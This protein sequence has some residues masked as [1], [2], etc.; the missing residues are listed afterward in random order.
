MTFQLSS[1][2]WCRRSTSQTGSADSHA[3]SAIAN[4]ATGF[5]VLEIVPGLRGAGGAGVP[6]YRELVSASLRRL[7]PD[8]YPS[9]A[10]VAPQMVGRDDEDFEYS[11]S[12]IVAGIRSFHEGG[13]AT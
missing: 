4:Y 6:E 12:A 13:A 9:A 1:I 2:S 3:I 8:A 10:A 7:P 11:V 5:T